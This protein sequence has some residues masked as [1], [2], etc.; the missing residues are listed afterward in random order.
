LAVYCYDHRLRR[1][2][3]DLLD[4]IG[5]SADPLSHAG[6]V[7]RL[8]ALGSGNHH[9]RSLREDIQLGIEL[10]GAWQMILVAHEDCGAYGLL[11]MTPEE[12]YH[13]QLADLVLATQRVGAVYPGQFKVRRFY[14]N[15][16]GSFREHEDAKILLV[17]NGCSL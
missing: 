15:L 6:G 10:H 11:G 1:R 5:V 16:D 17:A 8:L 7:R 12:T 3:L 9:D 13:T 4:A 14:L 2:H